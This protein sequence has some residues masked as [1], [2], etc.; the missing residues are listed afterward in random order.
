[1]L[2]VDDIDQLR[3]LDLRDQMITRLRTMSTHLPV[4]VSTVN[5]VDEDAADRRISLIPTLKDVA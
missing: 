2:V 1:M 3:S 4:V 5:P